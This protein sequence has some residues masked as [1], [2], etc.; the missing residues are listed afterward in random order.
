[1]RSSADSGDTPV[2]DGASTFGVL[3]NDAEGS[4]DYLT[5][6]EVSDFSASSN[7]AGRWRVNAPRLIVD[8]T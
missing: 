8:A 7:S 3:D 5:G 1:M 2:R 6:L 4:I